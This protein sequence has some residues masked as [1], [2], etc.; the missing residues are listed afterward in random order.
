MLAQINLY[1]FI[2]DDYGD[3]FLNNFFICFAMFVLLNVV[4]IVHLFIK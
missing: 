2:H 4:R 3:S 1:P